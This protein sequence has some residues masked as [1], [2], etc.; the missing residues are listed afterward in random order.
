MNT[1]DGTLCARCR[2]PTGPQKF[3]IKADGPYCRT[4]YG[5]PALTPIGFPCPFCNGTGRL[6][7]PEPGEMIDV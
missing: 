7:K 2:Q 5:D 4:C 3:Y 1:T 6:R